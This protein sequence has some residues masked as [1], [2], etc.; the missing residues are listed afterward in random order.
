M[1][2]CYVDESGTAETLVKTDPDQQPVIVVAGVSLP[3]QD[4]TKITHEWIKLKTRFNPSI[5]K[6]GHGWL[7]AILKEVKGAKLRNG[8]RGEPSQRQRKQ[9]LGMIDGTLKLLERHDAKILG[10]I[11]VKRL[12]DENDDMKIHASSLQFIC[13]AFDAGLPSDERGMVVVDSQTYQHNHRL[14]HSVFTQRFG[15]DPKHCGLVDM[16]VFGHSDNHAGLQI[17][18]LLC[19]AVL[20]PIASAV[21]TG[22]YSGWN[23]HCDSNYLDIREQF[24]GRLE[25]LTYQW[26]N[27]GT[28][29]K[30]YSL[31]VSDPLSKRGARLMWGP[32]TESRRRNKTDRVTPKRPRRRRQGQRR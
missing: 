5:A 24:G 9:A 26:T 18:D 13:G 7:D 19:S 2:L 12:G 22:S 6:S 25:K 1:Q 27:P 32:R 21:Y 10:R 30:R 11:W 23:R 28:D 17:A 29:Q 20:A 14:A 4:L 3:E 15:K 16:P 8:F 31:V